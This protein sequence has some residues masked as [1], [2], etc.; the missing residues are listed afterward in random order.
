ML[1]FFFHFFFHFFVW[2]FETYSR[3]F[4]SMKKKSIKNSKSEISN[5]S[6]KSIVDRKRLYFENDWKNWT[7]NWSKKKFDEIAIWNFE[8]LFMINI[9][10]KR[11]SNADEFK[12]DLL[13]SEIFIWW[14]ILRLQIYITL[15]R[16]VDSK[17]FFFLS[18]FI[19]SF[20]YSTDFIIMIFRFI[21]FFSHV[22]STFATAIVS[23]NQSFEMKKWWFETIVIFEMKQ[24]DN[25]LDRKMKIEKNSKW[26][27]I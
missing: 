9:V 15:F 6:K 1:Q 18:I 2:S 14:N 26:K 19:Q 21:S 22:S 4:S 16:Y 11:N 24:N 27:I 13:I 20:F 3:F 10:W 8:T 23:W 7:L 25:K 17:V 12:C 5:D